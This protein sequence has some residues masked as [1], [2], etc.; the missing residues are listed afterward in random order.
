MS[1]PKPLHSLRPALFALMLVP[2]A[3]LAQQAPADAPAPPGAGGK[4]PVVAVVNGTKL[5]A[6]D[7]DA[8]KKDLGP[9]AEG[10]DYGKLL[11]HM[12]TQTVIEQAAHADKTESDPEYQRALAQTAK[13]LLI[14]TYLRK[15]MDK[16]VTDAAIK[17]KYDEMVKTQ[18]GQE[19]VKARHILLKTEDEAKAIIAELDKGADFAKLANEKSTDKGEDGGELGY[20]TKDKMVP[21][22]ANAA[23]AM[24]VGQHS[25][26][27]VKSQFGYHVILVEDRRPAK[28][29]ALEEVRDE[30]QKELAN[31]AIESKVDELKK[32]ATIQEFNKDGT[33]LANADAGDMTL[34]PQKKK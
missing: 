10:A 13:Q 17:A 5:H 15:S 12:V 24:K 34:A 2:A 26:T 16:A 4:D 30:I 6:S 18:G 11:D 7:Y 27:P 25:A 28:P 21:E 22:F 14:R 33:P 9:Q 1:L 31:T 8:L 32:K 29:P 20:F 3:A 23:F 19:E